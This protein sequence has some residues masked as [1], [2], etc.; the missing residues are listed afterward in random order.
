MHNGLQLRSSP[1]AVLQAYSDIRRPRSQVVWDASRQ[2]GMVYDH[3]GPHGPTAEGLMQD[4]QDL[5]KPIWRH[6]LDVE[7]NEAARQLRNNST[8]SQ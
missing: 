2:A 1:Q 3:H 6:D 7:F 8:F 5:W 4:L